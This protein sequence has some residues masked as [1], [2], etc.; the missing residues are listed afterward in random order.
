[1]GKG[2]LRRTDKLSFVALHQPVSR[3]ETGKKSSASLA[4]EQCLWFHYPGTFQFHTTVPAHFKFLKHDL[5][6]GLTFLLLHFP[7][8]EEVLDERKDTV[9][10]T[11]RISRNLRW[12]RLMTNILGENHESIAPTGFPPRPSN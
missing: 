5:L 8:M 2:K 1:M 10:P 4:N 12:W 9:Y 3:C 7:L 11:V 6:T